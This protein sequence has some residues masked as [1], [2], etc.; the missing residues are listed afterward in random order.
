MMTE[1][2]ALLQSGSRYLIRLGVRFPGKAPLFAG[3]KRGGFSAYFGD[4]PIVHTDLEGRWQRLYLG[5]T[6]YLRGLDGSIVAIDRPRVGGILTLRRRVLHQEEV[7]PLNRQVEDWIAALL[8]DLSDPRTQENQATW[9][10]AP[11]PPVERMEVDQ[12]VRFLETILNQLQSGDTYWTWASDFFGALPFMPPD[13][14]NCLVL[15]VTR[16][17]EEPSLFTPRVTGTYQVRSRLDFR[18]ECAE[19]LKRLGAGIVPYRFL[20][21]A[22]QNAF[23]RSV[24]EIEA[25]LKEIADLF[26]IARETRTAQEP[27][28]EIYEP[29]FEGVQGFLDRFPFPL[30]DQASWVRFRML[31]LVRMTLGFPAVDPENAPID[32]IGTETWGS[33]LEL[34]RSLKAAGLGISILIPLDFPDSLHPSSVSPVFINGWS[35]LPLDQNDQLYLIDVP[36][37]PG[38]DQVS[39]GNHGSTLRE[40]VQLLRPSL[41]NRGVR[42]R[43]YQPQKQLF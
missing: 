13:C 35:E 17:S 16:G 19:L 36:D 10:E 9:F 28:S 6:H 31:G 26:P 21:L 12:L 38:S 4:E 8:T 11:P 14:Q 7:V 33:I 39:S 23:R 25:N 29:Q 30:P 42:V 3:F 34:I 40:I 2:E 27:I 1:A 20:Y 15:P 18:T 22:G 43:T 41:R 5:T 37:L 24:E 32:R